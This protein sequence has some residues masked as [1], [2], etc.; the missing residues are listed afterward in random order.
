MDIDDHVTVG[1][2]ILLSSHYNDRMPQST[3]FN[4]EEDS[5]STDLVHNILWIGNVDLQQACTNENCF[6]SRLGAIDK[7]YEYPALCTSPRKRSM[8]K[9][10]PISHFATN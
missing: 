10:E 9:V 3:T 8:T 6:A 5:T 1:D 4:Q 7:F 2:G